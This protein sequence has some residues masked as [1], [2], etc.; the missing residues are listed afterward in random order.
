MNIKTRRKS[1][2]DCFKLKSPE[3]VFIN[4][5]IQTKALVSEVERVLSGK[6]EKTLKNRKLMV[7]F[8]HPNTH[9]EM[10]IGHMRTL[11]VG[12]S[13]ARITTPTQVFRANYQGDIGPH[14]AKSI[15]GTGEIFERGKIQ[16]G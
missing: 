1:E 2:K 9:K 14:V 12:E 6:L 16:L 5:S 4:I 13:L 7:E 15:W 10:H 3:L 8:A 11:I